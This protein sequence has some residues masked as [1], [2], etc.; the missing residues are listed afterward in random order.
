[1]AV[2]VSRYEYDPQTDLIGKG[3]FARVFK[4]HDTVL[5]RDV[6]LKIY[7][8]EDNNKY[9][10][11][12][13]I[14]KVIKFEHPNLCRY[15][16]VAMLEGASPTGET[17][18]YQVG[19]MEYVDGG[20]I[21]SFLQKNPSWR[22]KLLTDVIDGLEFLH[23]N[24]II[25][26]DLK[27]QNILVRNTINGPVAAITDFGISKLQDSDNTSSSVL[28]GTLQYMAPEQLDPEH[29]AIHGRINFNLDYWYFGNIVYELVKGHSL[30]T[31]EI[32]NTDTGKVLQEILFKEIK[33][34][35][36][37]L[38]E[39]YKTIVQACLV[40]DANQRTIDPLFLKNSLSNNTTIIQQEDSH[41]EP[42]DVLTKVFV[43]QPHAVE[44]RVNL[45]AENPPSVNEEVLFTTG[46]TGDEA[47]VIKKSRS[48][49]QIVL[50]IVVGL[51]LTGMISAGVIWRKS[52]EDL[53]IPDVSDSSAAT[54]PVAIMDSAASYAADTLMVV[55]DSS[56]K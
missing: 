17:L 35:I 33:E 41:V 7:Y 12:A 56:V 10:L 1:M 15:Y 42:A 34:E 43:K 8:A 11:L 52:S 2:I 25:H 4:A 26:R 9:D 47:A 48:R 36:N 30:F 22:N 32:K 24:G 6:A 5:Q 23:R 3:G 13:E 45:S 27:P 18:R 16:D 37:I 55:P 31:R 29:Y 44:E 19:I 21:K 50:Y 38:D 14:R 53:F 46:Q 40:K 51:L 49:Q 54:D 20:D 28:M 39:P